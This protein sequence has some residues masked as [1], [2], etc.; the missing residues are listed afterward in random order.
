MQTRTRRC[1]QNDSRWLSA[2]ARDAKRLRRR[3]ERR[4]HRTRLAVDKQAFTNARKAARD[5]IMKS[6][7]DNI[8]T[9]MLEV[10]GDHRAT[11]R[12]AQKLL[13]SKPPIYQDD[14]DCARLS[15]SFSQFFIDKLSLI[16]N[17]I[18]TALESLPCRQLISRSFVGN[19]LPAFR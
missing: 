2:E 15:T 9:K 1:G 6:R 8:R 12:M 7:A 10:N 14:A 16:R 18:A 19:D 17:N 11:W 4:Y 5:S 3:L 13:H